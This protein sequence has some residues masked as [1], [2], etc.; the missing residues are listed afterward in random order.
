MNSCEIKNSAS[1]FLSAMGIPAFLKPYVKWDYLGREEL[2]G[3]DRYKYKSLDTSPISNYLTHPFWNR[4]VKFFPLWFAPNLM[5]FIGWLF[6][7]SVYLVTYYYDP[8]F[9]AGLGKHTGYHIPPN[10]W[11]YFA[12][13]QFLAHTLDGIDGK[14]ARRTN[15]S[16]PLGELFDHGLDSSA[17]WLITIGLF[18]VFGHGK[19]CVTV[20]E[21]YAI[22]LICL[23]GFFLAH[24]EKYNTGVLNLPWAYDGSQLS[25]T[26]V[27]LLTYAFGTEF[28][29]SEMAYLGIK[30]TDGFRIIVYGSC[31]FLTTPMCLYS[32]YIAHKN[33]SGRGISVTEGLMPFCPLVLCVGLFTVWGLISPSDILNGHSKLFV[34]AVGIVY[35]NITCRL[36]V[37]TMCYQQCERFNHLLYPLIVLVLLVPFLHDGAEY[38]A[39]AF[40]TVIVA[41]AH[42]HYGISVVNELCDHLKIKCFSLKKP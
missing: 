16:T 11:I 7:V 39:L 8:H 10:W 12:L 37:S 15:S 28:W 35:S 22:Y 26:G 40:Y 30:Y 2:A 42:L 19:G 33:N 41:V 32:V 18:S 17:V 4:V 34:T 31:I 9:K 25:I 38:V 13:A 20:W 6:L 1:G 3:F 14:Q 27:Y 21:F 24:W 36:I 23:L 5:T 29:K